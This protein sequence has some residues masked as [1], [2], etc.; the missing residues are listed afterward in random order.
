MDNLELLHERYAKALFD[1]GK[2]THAIDKI[3]QDLETLTHIIR[4]NDE[5]PLLLRHP[6]IG[7]DEKLKVLK[8]MSGIYRF[9]DGFMD[10]LKLLIRKNRLNLIHGVF[11]RHRDYYDI[12]RKKVKVFIRSAVELTQ[13]QINKL[14]GHLRSFLKEEI[15]LDAEVDPSLIGG[16][17]LKVH[18]RIYDASVKGMLHGINKRLAE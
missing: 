5:F 14:S 1:F 17:F 16:L 13:A 3:M 18:D 4:S 9:C 8:A 15:I 2:H 12:E 11:L 7:K 10:F 6:E